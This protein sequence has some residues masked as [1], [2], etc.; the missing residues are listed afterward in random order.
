MFTNWFV[1][2]LKLRIHIQTMLDKF[3]KQLTNLLFKS[4]KVRLIGFQTGLLLICLLSI[5]LFSYFFVT[6]RVRNA[7]ETSLNQTID[8]YIQHTIHFPERTKAGIDFTILLPPDAIFLSLPKDNG[9]NPHFL[10]K[11]ASDLLRLPRY[12]GEYEFQGYQYFIV[13]KTLPSASKALIALPAQNVYLNDFQ[14][15]LTLLF[16]AMLLISTLI[17]YAIGLSI[18]QPISLLTR[19]A[20]EIAL[21]GEFSERVESNSIGEIGEL[22]RTFNQML[23]KMQTAHREINSAKGFVENIIT[24]M[25]E[26]LIILHLDESILMVN[27]A[28]IELL[29]YNENELLGEPIDLVVDREKLS[30]EYGSDIFTR[31]TS[32]KSAET[33]CITKNGGTISIIFSNS[34]MLN[35]EGQLEG[36]VCIA[37]DISRLKQAEIELRL[38]RE[39][40]ELASRTKSQF[41][42]NMS[43]EIRTPLN[44]IVGFSQILLNQTKQLALPSEQQQYLRNINIS[45][46]NLSEL[47]NNI[48]DLSKI[49][50]GKMTLSEEDVNL[51]LLVQGIYHINRAQALKKKIAFS[52][53]FLQGTP[54]M[55]RTDRTKLNQILM[56]LTGNAIK[57]TPADGSVRIVVRKL[58]DLVQIDVIDR[59]IGIPEGRQQSIFDAFEQADTGTT[60][61]YGGTGLGLSIAKKM[62]EL[63]KGDIKLESALGQG[64]HFI[65]TIPFIEA[66]TGE[67][68]QS[69][70]MLDEYRFSTDNCILLVEDN[71]MNQSMMRALFQ[72]LGLEIITADNGRDGVS[73]TIELRPDL[74]LMDI[75]MPGMDG[76][77]ATRQI[78]QYAEC[79]KIPIVAISAHAFSDQQREAF[80]AGVNN[81][82]TKPLDFNKFFPV[83]IQYLRHETNAEFAGSARA[84]MP[85]YIKMQMKEEFDVMAKI[86]IFKDEL[87]VDQIEKMRTL[88]AEYESPFPAILDQIEKAAFD[89]NETQFRQFMQKYA[90]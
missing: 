19:I 30:Q 45:G 4:V 22:N 24:S 46:Q 49:E 27:K 67:I 12:T 86:S 60:R 8:R 10:R 63:L 55:I 59:G 13:M 1:P 71:P 84:P 90:S 39:R 52:Y 26:A 29:G 37:Q 82:L 88:C 33:T 20:S 25:N 81:Y 15:S 40:A 70:T 64:S 11:T 3:R 16:I 75:H 48:L 41:L 34:Y 65:V 2:L 79:E 23:H 32:I 14:I 68:R 85:D 77:T 57:F 44:S 69:Y 36:I 73:K 89:S 83:L 7:L 31:R 9:P 56:N 6:L 72:N 76:I 18:S 28:A 21:R 62:I 58:G 38:A 5:E 51:K 74:V 42:A 43:H 87:I 17:A 47:I 61:E 54:E 66:E 35:G 78:R 80:E 53:D 50:A